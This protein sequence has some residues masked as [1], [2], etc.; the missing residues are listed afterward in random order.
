MGWRCGVISALHQVAG[1]R[2]DHEPYLFTRFQLQGV[3]SG[4]SE[5]NF[6]QNAAFHLGRDHDISLLERLNAPRNHVA[7]AEASWW[8]SGQQD[9][10]GADSYSQR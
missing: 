10:S 3:A 1:V 8:R 9:V 2:F 7:R 5:M 6:H 4:H